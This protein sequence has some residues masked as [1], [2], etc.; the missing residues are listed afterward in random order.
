MC[1]KREHV[2]DYFY[3]ECDPA[4][5]RLVEAHVN[6]CESCRDELR[7]WRSVRTDLLAW[8]VPEQ[9]SVWTPFAPPR[10]VP[11]YRQV[12]AWAMAA[13]ATV[14]FAVG[15][16]GGFVSRAAV[17]ALM[18]NPSAKAA[19]PAMTEAQVREIARTEARAA[20][21]SAVQPVAAHQV[22]EVSVLQRANAQAGALVA[23]SEARM[24]QAQG[25]Q[26]VS[27]YQNEDQQRTRDLNNFQTILDGRF[28]TMSSVIA[29]DVWRNLR[30]LQPSQPDPNKKER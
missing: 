17:E 24:K 26:M 6:S 28:K 20:A 25:A 18:A 15:A 16:A 21:A 8:D 22:D 9:P 23:A 5:R 2:L 14:V 30:A 29:A 1:E 7:G 10:P 3:D 11:W 19:T 13:A 12:P 27:F 4:E